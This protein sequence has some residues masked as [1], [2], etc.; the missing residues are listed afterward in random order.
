MSSIGNLLKTKPEELL[1]ELSQLRDRERLLIQE[2]ELLER[3][4]EMRVENG[5]ISVEWLND[6]KQGPVSIGPLRAQILRV[7]KAGPR[8]KWLPKAVHQKL[9][10]R[11]NTKSSLANVRATM[12]RMV[13]SGELVRLDESPWFALPPG[14]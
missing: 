14:K 7:M 1:Q 12:R 9:V 6:A 2:K 5:E 3:V 4:L 10:A 13:E 11:G 8:S